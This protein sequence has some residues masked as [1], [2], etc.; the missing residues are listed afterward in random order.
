MNPKP[1]GPRRTTLKPAGNLLVGFSGGLG[2]TVLLDLVHRCYVSMDESTMPVD[3]GKLHPRHEQ[4]WKKVTVCYVEICDAFPGMQDRTAEIA[5]L[6]ARHKG[7]EFVPLRLQDAFNERW[8]TEA[9]GRPES[10]SVH[11]DITK[12]KL[13]YTLSSSTRTPAE[14]LRAYLASLPT[15]TAIQ[16]SINTMIRVLLLH[17][18][19]ATNSS[20]LILGTSLTNLAMSLISGISQGRGFN[21][22]EEMQEDWVPESPSVETDGRSPDPE[23]KNGRREKGKK[24]SIRVLRPLRDMGRK[25]CAMWV[26]WN[27]LHVV[28]KESRSW[29]GTKQDIGSLTED[30]IMGLEKDY[31]STVS[32]IV[33]TCSKVAPKGQVAGL[34]VLCAR[35]IQEGIQEW[36]SRISIRSRSSAKPDIS[37]DPIDSHAS[38]MQHLCYACHTTLT[39]RSSRPRPSLDHSG[40]EFDSVALPVWVGPELLERDEVFE[41][42]QLDDRQKRTVIQE[43]LLDD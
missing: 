35:P 8:L 7:L 10:V 39:S 9:G 33:R 26:W 24:R 14:A 15:A 11:I 32:T 31:P 27:G 34:C 22:K 29:L 21:V 2:S 41:S 17:T 18:A 36:K 30:F 23:G 28:G 6:I 43:F 38:L 20:H 3:G 4:V 12:E 25:E 37:E 16:T 19:M 42:S 40:A 13:P 5:D 1:D